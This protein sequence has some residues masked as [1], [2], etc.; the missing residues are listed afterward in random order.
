MR[1]SL[2]VARDVRVILGRKKY[3]RVLFLTCVPSEAEGD[4]LYQSKSGGITYQFYCVPAR[5]N[6]IEGFFNPPSDPVLWFDGYFDLAE[7]GVP[8]K[9]FNL[10]KAA[11]FDLAAVAS[12]ICDILFADD[13]KELARKTLEKALRDEPELGPQKE[14]WGTGE[15]E[16][17]LEANASGSDASLSDASVEGDEG[18]P[19]AA[20][21]DYLTSD[22]NENAALESGNTT[23][24]PRRGGSID[25]LLPDAVFDACWEIIDRIER[26]PSS[27]RTTKEVARNSLLGIIGW[28][29]GLW[30]WRR[31]PIE[32]GLWDTVSER[33]HRWAKH[34]VYLDF[35]GHKGG[36]VLRA[37]QMHGKDERTPE[38]STSGEC[39]AANPDHPEP[40]NAEK[41]GDGLRSGGPAGR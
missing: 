40:G 34:G 24:L 16:D 41:Q 22:D 7:P 15:N 21:T 1:P 31:M 11:S 9:G 17:P 3:V 36:R 23:A 6:D 27:N 33:F 18:Q 12:L 30:D 37:S 35:N 10:A 38:N 32:Y 14:A 26:N 2:R 5:Y 28:C 29:K 19:D 4:A 20:M 39:T 25:H 8:W 13:K